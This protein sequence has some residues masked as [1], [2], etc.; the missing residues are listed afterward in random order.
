MF[1]SPLYVDLIAMR[2]QT[3]YKV[4]F[5]NTQTA[6]FG[7]QVWCAGVILVRVILHSLKGDRLLMNAK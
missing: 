7:Q 2:K 6:N 5:C 1:L 4:V 3:L